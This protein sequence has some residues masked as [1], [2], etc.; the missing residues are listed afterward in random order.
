MSGDQVTYP[1]EGGQVP[2]SKGLMVGHFM[3]AWIIL[4]NFNE[5][6]PNKMD[7]RLEKIPLETPE[8]ED[9]PNNVSKRKQQENDRV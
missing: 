2:S 8:V 3:Y 1:S 5:T 6:S 9:D 4:F 7:T